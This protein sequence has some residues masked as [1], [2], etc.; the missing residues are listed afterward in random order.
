[1]TRINLYNFKTQYSN[2]VNFFW[3]HT[4]SPQCRINTKK[5]VRCVIGILNTKL[6]HL[7]VSSYSKDPNSKVEVLSHPSSVLSTNP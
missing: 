5:I 1:M 3:S 7:T 6:E 4:S 2:D